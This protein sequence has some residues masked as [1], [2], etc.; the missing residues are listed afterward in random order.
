MD[1]PFETWTKVTLAHGNV[2]QPMTKE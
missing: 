1:E 2:L